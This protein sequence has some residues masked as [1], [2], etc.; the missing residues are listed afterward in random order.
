VIVSNPPYIP[1][2]EKKEIDS[3]VS[4]HEPGSALFVP[5]ENPLLFYEAITSFAKEHLSETGLLTFE[6]HENLAEQTKSLIVSMGFE[7]EIQ[8]DMFGKQRMISA[9]RCR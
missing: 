8:K 6:V 7:A 3:N 1:L 5:D 9:T 2:A 4:L